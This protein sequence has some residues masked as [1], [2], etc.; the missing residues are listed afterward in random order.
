MKALVKI[1]PIVV[2]LACAA[3]LFF[4]FKLSGIKEGLENDKQELSAKLTTTESTLDQTKNDLDGA[5]TELKQAKDETIEVQ[6]QLDGVKVDLDKK[7]READ[8]LTAKVAR[9]EDDV[10]TANEEKAE[11][12][13]KVESIQKAMADVG[14]TDLSEMDKVR[15][16]V[17]AITAENKVLGEQLKVTKEEN[18]RLADELAAAKTT[19]EG[20]RGK[21]ALAKSLWNFVVLD[22]GAEDKVQPQ[23]KFIVYRDS[24]LVGKAHVTTVYPSSSVAELDPTFTTTSPKAGDIVI[25]EKL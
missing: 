14:L 3:S 15:E 22:V 6:A 7:K 1:A 20:L 11:A 10:K 25:H 12:V 21:V 5:Q 8:E 19:P 18:V 4:S 23:S 9:L 13:G 24:Q 16:K 17:E 2:I